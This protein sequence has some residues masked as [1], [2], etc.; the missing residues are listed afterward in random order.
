MP[1]QVGNQNRKSLLH[2]WL[3]HETI[4]LYR[5]LTVAFVD[6]KIFLVRLFCVPSLAAPGTTAPFLR[7]ASAATGCEW[8]RLP[9][10]VIAAAADAD[11]TD[12]GRGAMAAGPGLELAST[13]SWSRRCG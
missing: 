9:L 2:F 4:K 12:A 6:D 11:F 7:P 3:I 10:S 8:L 1:K 13:M 5:I